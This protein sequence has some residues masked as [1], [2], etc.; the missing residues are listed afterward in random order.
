ME[1]EYAAVKR[2]EDIQTIPPIM[3]C[4]ARHHRL[5]SGNQESWKY[6][7]WEIMNRRT[8]SRRPMPHAEP[9]AL[10]NESL[11][12]S[13]N[14]KGTHL[15][16]PASDSQWTAKRSTSGSTTIVSRSWSTALSMAD[17]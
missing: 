17:S 9:L 7:W 11:S 5:K 10:W 6:D 4:H 1:P 3:T 15:R 2:D 13:H 16:S 14:V 8:T 12:G